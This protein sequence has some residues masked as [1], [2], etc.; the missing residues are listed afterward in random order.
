MGATIRT[1]RSRG[2]LILTLLVLA[3][4][5][6][7]NLAP[8]PAFA[9]FVGDWDATKLVLTS[10]ANPDIAPDL[11]AMGASFKLNIQPSGQYTA[12][13][14]YAQQA[15][16]EIGTIS[17]SG[18]TV[19]LKRDFPSPSTTAAVFAMSGDRLTLD[20]NT[21]FDFNLDGTPEAA[22][23]HFELKRR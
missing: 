2:S 11:I 6:S 14:I 9:P 19:T 1:K 16:T 20:G 13:L 22:V 10:V 7:E 4:C 15:S 21:E 12:I 18:N 5:G 8:D 3:A 23:A 17:V